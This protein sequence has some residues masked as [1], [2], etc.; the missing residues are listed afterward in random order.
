MQFWRRR[1]WARSS[2]LVTAECQST[3]P[4]IGMF[5][6]SLHHIS[7]VGR[8]LLHSLSCGDSMQSVQ[9]GL[10]ES[11]AA[12]MSASHT[13]TSFLLGKA[14]ALPLHPPPQPCPDQSP[15]RHS[16]SKGTRLM[17]FE[18]FI[19]FAWYTASAL[20]TAHVTRTHKQPSLQAFIIVTT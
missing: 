5:V 15:E 18:A 9:C 3:T 8:S 10:H 2:R 17:L 1:L 14:S 12:A 20:P 16:P 6:G 19:I 4:M 7:K 11:S 13:C